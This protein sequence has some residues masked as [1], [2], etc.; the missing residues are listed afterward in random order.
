[1]SVREKFGVLMSNKAFVYMTVAGFFR[2]M[3]GYSLGFWNKNYFQNVYPEK[4]LDYVLCYN[5]ILFLGGVPS[6]LIGGYLCDKYEPVIPGIKGLISAAGAFLGSI[7]IVFTF[8]IK[9]TFAIQ[10]VCFYFEY[11]TAE[12]F[13]GPTY[14]Q[15]NKIVPSYIQGLAVAVFS[16]AGSISGSTATYTLG[17]LGDKY[18]SE[19]RIQENP[20]IYGN[21]LGVAMLIGY[22]GCIPFFLLNSCEY[23][24]LV[25]AQWEVEKYVLQLLSQKKFN[26]SK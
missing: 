26:E 8:M 12:V 1:M 19:G 7:F 5:L 20:Q 17:L 18:K 21:V 25:R 9:S 11:L 2:F 13:F 6:E 4:Q 22:L 15:I 23:A 24:K 16:M 10:I 3:A 14:S